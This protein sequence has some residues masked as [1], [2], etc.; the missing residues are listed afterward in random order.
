MSNRTGDNTPL[1]LDLS[2]LPALITPSP[3]SNTLLI[4][5]LNDPFL[6]HP[7]AAISA[8]QLLDGA[9]STILL[10]QQPKPNQTSQQNPQVE[11]VDRIRCYFGPHTPV[12]GVDE[13]ADQ[14][15]KAPST[16]KLFFI[17]PPPSPPCGWESKE[18]DPPN[19][20]T[21]A[22]DLEQALASLGNGPGDIGGEK[23]GEEVKATEVRKGQQPEEDEEMEGQS[24]VKEGDSRAGSKSFTVFHPKQHGSREDLPAVMVVDTSDGEEDGGDD[25]AKTVMTHTARPPVELMEE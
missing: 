14:H 15:L 12:S 25:G 4:T 23:G 24:E 20:E 5:N 13:E 7:E 2:A 6:F 18:E 17:S 16:G 9:P 22:W 1:T 8:R 3:P 10:S 19:K 11:S 21:H